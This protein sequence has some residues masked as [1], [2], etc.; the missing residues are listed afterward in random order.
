MNWLQCVAIYEEER[1]FVEKFGGDAFD[2]LLSDQEINT[3]DYDR[4]PVNLTRFK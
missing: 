3:L 1:A 2:D 4:L